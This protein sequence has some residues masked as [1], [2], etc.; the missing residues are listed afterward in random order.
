MYLPLHYSYY[1]PASVKSSTSS[2][3]TQAA[4]SSAIQQSS[5]SSVAGTI[6]AAATVSS[7][8]HKSTSSQ[9]PK[10]ASRLVSG[11]LFHEANLT[12]GVR[13]HSRGELTASSAVKNGWYHPSA[14][15]PAA[16]ALKTLFSSVQRNIGTPMSS[17]LPGNHASQLVDS[18]APLPKPPAFTPQSPA[19]LAGPPH[20]GKKVLAGA[21]RS[22]SGTKRKV[23]P[24]VDV[25]SVDEAVWAQS[26]KPISSGPV[27][28]HKQK[29][30]NVGQS[31]SSSSEPPASKKQRKQK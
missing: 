27:T 24:Y 30:I 14:P 29:Q 7:S 25:P 1:V 26:A 10:L 16:P 19:H 9:P 18:P 31:A 4:G 3:T 8:S 21:E 28:R 20:G 6:L 5:E 23:L 15:P 22:I 13:L 2:L 12:S 17:P 11:G